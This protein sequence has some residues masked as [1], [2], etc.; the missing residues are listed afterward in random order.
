MPDGG[1][2]QHRGFIRGQRCKY[3]DCGESLGDRA[4]VAIALFAADTS[5]DVQCARRES[6][7]QAG[8]AERVPDS[9]PDKR[10]CIVVLGV[11]DQPVFHFVIDAVITEISDSDNRRDLFRN[12]IR[13]THCLTHD[14]DCL[15]GRIRVERVEKDDTGVE[16]VARADFNRLF[17][18]IAIGDQNHVI[19]KRPDLDRAPAYLFHDAVVSLSAHCYHVAHLKRPVSLERDS[20]EEIAERVLKSKTENDAEYRGRGKERAEIYFRKE[21]RESDQKED[22]ENYDREDVSDEGGRVDLLEPERESEE[23]SVECAD[24][25]VA[26]DADKKQLD[27]VDYRVCRRRRATSHPVLEQRFDFT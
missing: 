24:K 4:A 13:F 19:L 17:G 10:V 5:L 22:R 1:L 2:R 20:R 14:V 11:I 21:K 18:G 9:L 27:R 15:R 25:K 8:A 26:D 12:V 6:E 16:V 23:E 7:V 3:I